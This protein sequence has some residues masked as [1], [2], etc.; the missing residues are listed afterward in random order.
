MILGVCYVAKSVLVTENMIGAD[1]P[2]MFQMYNLRHKTKHQRR[3]W[4]FQSYESFLLVCL[5]RQKG[6]E[7]EMG[8]RRREEVR[9]EGYLDLT[10]YLWHILFL[11]KPHSSLATSLSMELN[12]CRKQPDLCDYT[13]NPEQGLGRPFRQS[14]STHWPSCPHCCGWWYSIFL[15]NSITWYRILK[16]HITYCCSKILFFEDARATLGLLP[17]M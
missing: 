9:V 13:W 17:Q 6:R 12:V 15:L 11:L 3:N 10:V 7:E 5:K 2:L 14:N 4:S 8:R 16:T 1:H